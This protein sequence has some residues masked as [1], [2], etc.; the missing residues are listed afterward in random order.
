MR[1][2]ESLSCGLMIPGIEIERLLVEEEK[3]L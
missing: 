3:V 2:T 1:L